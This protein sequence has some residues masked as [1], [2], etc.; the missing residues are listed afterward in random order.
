M[1][2]KNILRTGLVLLVFL[3]LLAVLSSANKSAKGQ[4]CT[5]TM[6]DCCKK[7]KNAAPSGETILESLPHRF[8][9]SLGFE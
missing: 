6:E 9:S 2:K 8:F 7:Q 4:K 5:E 3:A 1:F